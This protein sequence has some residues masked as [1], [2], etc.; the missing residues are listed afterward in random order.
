MPKN[1]KC[2]VTDSTIC[3]WL[4]KDCKDCYIN[5]I[6]D[7]SDAQKALFDFEITL[8]LL[9][10]GFDTLQS[11][12]CCFCVNEPGRRAG[13]AAIDLAHK[14]PEHKRGMFFG[15]GKKVRQRIGS[16]LP[17]SISICAR[18]R[19]NFRMAESLKWLMI[20]VFGGIAV[21]LCFLPAI[22]LSPA[23]PYG[24]VLLGI[25]I[26][27]VAGKIASSVYVNKKSAQT[28]FNVYDIPVCAKMRENGWFTVQDEG[29]VTRFLF[30]R[31]PMI[32]RLCDMGIETGKKQEDI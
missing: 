17:V 21:A 10:D 28:R 16:L 23:L 18:C 25:L 24:V 31:K 29:S 4:N 14:E 8:S 3:K 30:S 32:K 20:L 26:G 11:E 6:K 7:D 19:G 5:E 12:E 15:M 13:Y 27:Y 22:N 2:V 1:E 9:P